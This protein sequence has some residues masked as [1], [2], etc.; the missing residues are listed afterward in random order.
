[1]VLESF[2]SPEPG[3]RLAP[4]GAS[5]LKITREGD[6]SIVEF[7]NRKILD[8][9]NIMEIGDQLAALVQ[10]AMRPKIIIC[11]QGVDHLSSAA[12]GVFITISSKVKARD[13]QLRLCSIN[14]QIYEVFLIT[15]LNRMFRIYPTIK[16][17][18]ESLK[19]PNGG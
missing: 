8:E 3:E 11:F 12:L 1:M 14:P 18:L 17:S 5:S 4:P 2:A 16:E 9:V 10:T 13:G 15:K 19:A 6:A 7:T